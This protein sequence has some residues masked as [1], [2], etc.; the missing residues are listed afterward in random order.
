MAE[1]FHRPVVTTKT[2]EICECHTITMARKIARALNA[3]E[4]KPKAEPFAFDWSGVDRKYNWAAMDNDSQWNVY[5]EKPKCSEKHNEWLHARIRY[6]VE[7]AEKLIS[8]PP[9]PGDWRDSLQKRP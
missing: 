2:H 4:S 3:M 7:F 8:H 9:Y 6:V 1:I 5:D